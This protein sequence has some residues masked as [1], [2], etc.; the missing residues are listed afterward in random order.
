EVPV[1]LPKQTLHWQEVSPGPCHASPERSITVSRPGDGS[2]P[3]HC[4]PEY[5]VPPVCRLLR[6][7]SSEA[8]RSGCSAPTVLQPRAWSYRSR[9]RANRPEAATAQTQVRPF[10]LRAPSTG[11]L[12]TG[13]LCWSSRGNSEALPP[14]SSSSSSPRSGVHSRIDSALSRAGAPGGRHGSRLA[15]RVLRRT[16]GRP[17]VLLEAAPKSASSKRASYFLAGA[18][19]NGSWVASSSHRFCTSM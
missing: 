11:E 14:P 15:C 12:S 16:S 17:R 7:G 6:P 18:P 8:G 19:K 10:R 1:P 4:D 13:H 2:I 9:E 3:A 5:H